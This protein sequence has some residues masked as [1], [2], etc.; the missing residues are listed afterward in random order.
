[1]TCYPEGTTNEGLASFD[2]GYASYPAVV[3]HADAIGKCKGLGARA[4]PGRP[5]YNSN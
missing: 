4:Q 1:M 2:G 5:N 3:T